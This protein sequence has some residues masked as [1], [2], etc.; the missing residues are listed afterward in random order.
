MVAAARVLADP[1]DPEDVA[2]VNT[3]QDQ[4]GLKA[5]SA[6]PFAAP[7]TTSAAWMRPAPPCWSSNKGLFAFPRAFGAQGEVDPVHH[8]IGTAA[9][10]GRAARPRSLLPV[11]HPRPAAREVQLTVRDV[12]VDGFWSV[13]VYNAAGYFEPN[14]RGAYSV[15][16]ITAVHDQDGSVTIALRRLRGRPAQLPADH[17]GLE[18][19]RPP[20][21]APRRDPRRQLDLPGHLT[22]CLSRD[23]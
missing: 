8:L 13:S 5:G 22:K 17:G 21:P 12:P 2:A 1:A 23:R 3:L 20:L 9:G 4:F 19:H 14:D 16:N 18:L 7:T 11:R 10:L 6:R 15:N